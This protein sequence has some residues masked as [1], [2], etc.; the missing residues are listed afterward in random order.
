MK[1]RPATLD[2]CT[3]ISSLHYASFKKAGEGNFPIDYLNELTIETFLSRW[4]SRM[5]DNT[6][7]LVAEEDGKILGVLTAINFDSE[8]A[9]KNK[10]LELRYF[11][12]HVDHWRKGIGTKIAIAMADILIEAGYK[13]IYGSVLRDDLR[14]NAFYAALGAEATRS[15]PIWIPLGTTPE[16]Y[17]G[18]SYAESIDYVVNDITKALSLCSRRACTK[19]ANQLHSTTAL[20]FNPT[21]CLLSQDSGGSTALRHSQ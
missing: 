21:Q 19:D 15:K 13:S 11:Y 20:F 8:N 5:T 12:V 6:L 14:A 16:S 18:G 1:I 3:E 17:P 4:Q 2:D 7:T 10:A 9:G